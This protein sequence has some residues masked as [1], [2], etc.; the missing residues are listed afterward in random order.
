VN[1]HASKV[2]AQQV[3]QRISGQ[4]RQAVGNPVDLIR[5]VVEIGLGPLPQVADRLG[6]LL[7]RSGPDPKADTVE[8]VRGILLQNE[9]VVNTVRL[10]SAGANLY[11]MREASLKLLA[12]YAHEFL[13]KTY[14]HS[15][16]KR[17]SNLVILLEA[18]AASENLGQPELAYSTLHVAN[19]AL[20]WSWSLDPLRRFSSNTT[21]HVGMGQCLGC[22]LLGFHVQGRGDRLCDSGVERGCSAGNDQ[23]AVGLVARNRTAIPIAGPGP[24]EGSVGIERGSHLVSSFRLLLVEE[25]YFG[26]RPSGRYLR[27]NW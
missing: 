11:I 27:G 10:A 7:V 25:G 9:G 16:M 6:T 5:V 17:P 1:P 19:L 14:P 4:E 15:S 2:V 20:G 23:V 13:C 24:D 26:V 22:P 8:R 3:V 18:R 21:H 12:K